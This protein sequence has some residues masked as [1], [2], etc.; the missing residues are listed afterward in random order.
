MRKAFLCAIIAG[1]FVLQAGHV[2]VVAAQPYE[3][4][5][6]SL[7][8]R[9][10]PEWFLDGKFGIFIHWG[11][12]SVPAWAPK[13]QYSEWYWNRMG[14]PSGEKER[15]GEAWAFHKE[16]YGAD[17]AY[18]DFVPM[19]T[20]ELF[21]PDQWADLFQRSGAKY[22][23]LTSKH[24][25]GFCLFKSDIAN[26]SWGKPWNSVDAGPNRDLLGDLGE[27]VRAKGLRMGFYYSLYEWYNPLYRADRALFVEKHMIPQFKDV[28][29]RYKPSIIFSDG[30]WDEPSSFWKSEELLAWLFNETEVKDEVI[31]NDRWGKESRHV[32]GDYYTTEYASGMADASHPWEESRGMG[33][34]Y[35]YNRYESLDDY[36]T[37]RELTLMLIDLVSRGGN[38]LL[39][40]GPTGD[41]RIPVIMQQRLIDIGT[42]LQTNGEAIFGTRPWRKNRQWSD[43]E[44]PQVEFG[45]Q[46]MVKYEI[47][48]VTNAPKDGKAVV[49]A[50]FTSKGDTLY[51]IMPRWI[52]GSFLIQDVTP[53]EATRVEL[54]GSDEPLDWAVS[55]GGIAVEMP[56]APPTHQ[57]AWTLRLTGVQ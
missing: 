17:F 4:N 55:D 53:S 35:G 52:E 43:G 45:G 32:H 13:G 26:Q 3:A 25:D 9:P 8:A 57:T 51:A 33:H 47:N 37:S 20:A 48:E 28:V 56:C 11:V 2:S 39:N 46:Y 10:T 42:W 29:T 34:S 1:A 49:D 24:H 14:G 31:V 50:F 36:R 54:L 44:I 5:W 18:S 27:A 16:H 22:V 40:V 19:F 30:E 15:P 41:G 38:L 21:E 12:Y 7:D 6:E 23:V